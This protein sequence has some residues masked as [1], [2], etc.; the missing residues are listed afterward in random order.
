MS[1]VYRQHN[2]FVYAGYLQR[3]R[4]NIYLAGALESAYVFFCNSLP[5]EDPVA[6]GMRAAALVV[7]VD[8]S[9]LDDEQRCSCHI[10]R[11][12]ASC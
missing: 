7:Y 4:D 12:V 6:E 9:I 1:C 8:Y 3:E 10:E 11:A 5:V 2:S